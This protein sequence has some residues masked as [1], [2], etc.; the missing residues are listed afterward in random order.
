MGLCLMALG[1]IALFAP[2]NWGNGFM[3]AGFGVLQIVFGFWIAR[4][5]GG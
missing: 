5:H 3:A 4:H 1:G 2:A